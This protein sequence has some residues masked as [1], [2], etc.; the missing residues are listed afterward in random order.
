[1]PA[2]E[3]RYRI[4]LIR[5]QNTSCLKF[6]RNRQLKVMTEHHA[7]TGEE[8]KEKVGKEIK[9]YGEGYVALLISIVVGIIIGSLALNGFLE[10]TDRLRQENLGPFDEKV[11]SFIYN[12]RSEKMTNFVTVITDM[13]DVL[14]YS[15]IIVAVAIWF[16]IDKRSIRWLI[17]SFIILT[18]TS[19]LNIL[20]KHYISRPRPDIDMRLVEA[21]SYSYPSGHSM[22]ALAFYGFLIYLAYKKVE[23]KW[24]KFLAFIFLPL[25]I[26]GIGASRVYLGVHF[27]SDVIAGFAAGLFW[28]VFVILLVNIFRF[29]RKRKKDRE[30]AIAI[31]DQEEED[32]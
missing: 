8:V 12:Y 26:L 17:Q 22:C 24:I 21:S 13:G 10:L 32:D 16:L 4:T 9:W 15:I 14:A 25:L 29:Y 27:P 30:V 23:H 3:S 7:P 20:I 6:V 1:L 28:L 11:T 18:S 31:E 19:L 5:T 2:D